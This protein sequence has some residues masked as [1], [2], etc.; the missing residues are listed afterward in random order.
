MPLNFSNPFCRKD[1]KSKQE[2]SSNKKN[3]VPF[4]VQSPNSLV[5]PHQSM[6]NIAKSTFNKLN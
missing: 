4:P 3:I 1:S 6:I 5:Q 2:I